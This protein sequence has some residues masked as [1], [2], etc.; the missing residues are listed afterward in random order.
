MVVPSLQE[1]LSNS[2]MEALSCGTPVI[3]FNVGGNSDMIEHKKNGYLAKPFEPKD[4]ALGVE[5]VLD[6]PNYEDLR[7]N[8]R[9][10]VLQEFRSDLVAERYIK[11][12]NEILQGGK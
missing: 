9:E 2:I 1:N 10:K 7:I 5:W 12:Y 8:A 11:I 6:A 4:L 3:A